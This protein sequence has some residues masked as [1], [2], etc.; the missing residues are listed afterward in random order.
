MPEL[1][2]TLF[3]KQLR[4][5]HL[6][7]ARLCTEHTGVLTGWRK[8]RVTRRQCWVISAQSLWRL[9]T[10]QCWE[11]VLVE[12]ASN[13]SPKEVNQGRVCQARG[14]DCA[15][16][17]TQESQACEKQAHMAGEGRRITTQDLTGH[18][19]CPL[20]QG[21]G[22]SGMF[23][24]P[25]GCHG[26]ELT[27]RAR[28]GRRKRPRRRLGEGPGGAEAKAKCADSAGISQVDAVTG[29]HQQRWL[30]GG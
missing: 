16:P 3:R 17:Q 8:N 18:N 26:R 7:C 14:T 25:C 22:H 29:A 23:K 1:S 15:K 5:K 2:F 12:A 9:L 6:L 13:L 20:G 11:D 21:I 24:I 27:V 4:S 19:S 28:S 10:R 30:G